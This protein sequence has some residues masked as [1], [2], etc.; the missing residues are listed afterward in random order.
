MESHISAAVQPLHLV[1]HVLEQQLVFV[2]V[3]FQAAAE[4]AEQELH[5]GSGDDALRADKVTQGS[6]LAVFALQRLEL[7]LNCISKQIKLN[8]KRQ[9]QSYIQLTICM[10]TI[11]APT[12]L[13]NRKACRIPA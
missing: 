6:P 9:M 7:V 11:Y 4:E 12:D 2:Q 5:P 8:A 10:H 13:A 1:A 3:H